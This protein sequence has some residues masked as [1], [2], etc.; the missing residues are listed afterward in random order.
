MSIVCI[1]SGV[2][3][4]LS[5]VR[6]RR[7]GTGDR[8]T[9]RQSSSP[10]SV[11]LAGPPL[12]PSDHEACVAAV[13][14]HS[15]KTVVISTHIAPVS[16]LRG[17]ASHWYTADIIRRRLPFTTHPTSQRGCGVEHET[18]LTF[19]AHFRVAGIFGFVDRI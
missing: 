14:H 3:T 18:L 8:Y 16:A 13:R 19:I 4:N 17:G 12:L 10:F 1:N 9:G 11:C 15:S 5:I 2:L 7:R 6:F